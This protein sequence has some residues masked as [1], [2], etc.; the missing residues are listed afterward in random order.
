MT[1]PALAAMRSLISSALVM[2][3]MVGKGGGVS[4]FGMDGFLV[5]KPLAG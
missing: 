2:S 3:S 5:M 4:A 1:P